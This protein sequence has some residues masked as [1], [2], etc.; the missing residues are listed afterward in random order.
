VE[1]PFEGIAESLKK[2]RLRNGAF[3]F[4]DTAP[5]RTDETAAL[6][7]LADLVIVPVRPSPSDLW[8]AAATVEL[9]KREKVPFLFRSDSG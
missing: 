2:L 6:F 4:I 3:C 7:H 9:L 8:A 1:L 5:N